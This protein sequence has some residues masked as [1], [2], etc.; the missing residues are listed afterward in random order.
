M[1]GIGQTMYGLK[2]IL[3]HFP[4]G[5]IVIV[6]KLL[7]ILPLFMSLGGGKKILMSLLLE[8]YY[9]SVL[10]LSYSQNELIS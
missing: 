6:V 7:G 5:F 4:D 2:F 1:S 10:V 3:S 9:F 8:V